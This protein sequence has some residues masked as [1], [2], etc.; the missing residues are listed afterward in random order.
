MEK[1]WTCYLQAWIQLQ[2]L[3]PHQKGNLLKY[4]VYPFPSKFQT[5]LSKQG[6]IF[7]VWGSRSGER[8]HKV[9]WLLHWKD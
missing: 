6:Y 3:K 1:K 4:Q 5:N 9:L 7:E 2:I 8:L